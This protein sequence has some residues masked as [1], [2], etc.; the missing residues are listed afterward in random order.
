MRINLLT[1]LLSRDIEVE[2]TDLI[3]RPP[4]ISDFEQWLELRTKSKDF[5]R[6]WE[7][8]W[9]D[10][11]L[12]EIGYKRRMKNYATGFRTGK[13]RSY[14]LHETS[15]EKLLGGLSLTRI[16]TDRENSSAL[17]GYWMGKPHANK[18]YMQKAVPAIVGY[19]FNRLGLKVVEAAVIPRNERSVHLL[20]KCGFQKSG[21]CE[22]Y[23]EI[24]GY[25]EDHIL[26]TITQSDFKSAVR[27]NI[28]VL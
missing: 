24:N 5:L 22:K 2:G 9:P 13:A 27:H 23:L 12:S 20:E 7:P 3:L 28:R 18:G 11:D 6:Q 15:S 17:L 10:D 21:F 16:K 19:A 26:F 14:F 25:K 4:S 8:K 1:K